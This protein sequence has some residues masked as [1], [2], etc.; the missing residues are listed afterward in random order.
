M[1]KE[2]QRFIYIDLLRGWA[3]LV[4]IE[5]HVVNAFLLPEYRDSAWFEVLNFINGLVAPS[6]LFISGYSFSLIAQRKWNE[7]LTFNKTFWKQVGRILQVWI[8]GYALH[9][10]VFSFSKAL[11]LPAEGWDV[12]WK[13][14]IL[15]VIAFSLLLLLIVL[16]VARTEK[17]YFIFVATICLISIFVAPVF[18]DKNLDSFLAL[19]FANYL[20]A[21]N[22]SQF[23]LFPWMAFLLF[24]AITSQGIVWVRKNYREEKIFFWIGVVGTAVVVLATVTTFL[25]FSFYGEQ[26]YWRSSPSFFFIRLGIVLVFLATL[27]FW[28]QKY[29]SGQSA[30]SVVGSESL[31]AYAGHLLVIYGMF[32]NNHSLSFLIGKTRTIPEVAGMTVLLVIATM[33]V[34]YYWHQIK[35]WSMFYARVLQYSI[36]FIVLYVFFTKLA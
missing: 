32:F 12:F 22:R 27:W 31:V 24:G 7:Y 18:Y 21:A 26:N 11:Q 10:P 9:F 2:K 1:G 6:F 13:V 5:V 17:R 33:G 3:V 16:V 28:E 25:P 35:K 29:K 36:L 14:D 8:V 20:T 30:V 34:S 15:H 23:P 19:P 4:M